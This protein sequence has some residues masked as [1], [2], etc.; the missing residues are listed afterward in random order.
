MMLVT[1]WISA[2]VT[3]AAIGLAAGGA[4]LAARADD[5]DARAMTAT[6]SKA[7]SPKPGTRAPL[8][9]ADRRQAAVFTLDAAIERLLSA[10]D[11]RGGSSGEIPRAEGRPADRQCGLPCNTPHPRRQDSQLI[12][13]ADFSLPGPDAPRQSDINISHPVD[14]SHKRRSR[15]RPAGTAKTVA[16]AQYQDFMRNRIDSLYS[17]YVDA[18]ESQE[19]D[20]SS[21]ANLAR[22]DKLLRETRKRAEQGSVNEGE[23]E[24]DSSRAKERAALKARRRPS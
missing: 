19:R 22:W 24:P 21:A 13:Y 7:D 4:A 8:P 6:I 23:V 9:A 10:H 17:A 2:T 1:R 20:L 16:E 3:L 5:D 12:P 11:R 15:P 14:V 18:Q